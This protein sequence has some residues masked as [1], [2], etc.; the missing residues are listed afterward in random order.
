MPTRRIVLGFSAALAASALLPAFAKDKSKIPPRRIPGTDEALPVVGLGNS[1]SFRDQD[2]D[3]AARLLEIFSEHGGGYVDVGGISRIFVGTILRNRGDADRYFLANYVDANSATA[4]S[5]E[6]EQL[7]EAQ[8]KQALDLV[9]THDVANFRERHALFSKLKEQGLVR[10][11]GV[12]R[13]GE[14]HFDAIAALVEDGLVDFIQVNYSLLEPLAAERLLPLAA[15]NGVGVSINR[16]FINGRYFDV[17]RETP[18]PAW[19]ADFDC[20]S[21]AQ[22][23]LKYIIAHPAVTCVL[24]ETANPRHAQDN[25]GAGYGELPDA[26]MRSRMLEFVRNL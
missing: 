5:S 13:S 26:S 19:A 15:D 4:L 18:L 11:I 20:D 16:P 9:H 24:T 21:W 12:A 7:A 2:L 25:L 8:A 17:V 22:F 1:A 23:S 10:Y 14:Q 3:T 6:V